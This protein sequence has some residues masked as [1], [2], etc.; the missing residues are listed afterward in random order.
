MK[1]KNIIRQLQLVYEKHGDVDVVFTSFCGTNQSHVQF[2]LE[3]LLKGSNLDD[4]FNDR[5]QF[6]LN[7][8]VSE[9]QKTYTKNEIQRMESLGYR[10]YRSQY[11]KSGESPVIGLSNCDWH[12][13]W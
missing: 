2:D 1:I 10:Y 7:A 8:N 12:G 4:K 3:D 11:C 6:C 9:R 5:G 13:L